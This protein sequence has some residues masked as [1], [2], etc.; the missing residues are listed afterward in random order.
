MK[1]PS[2]SFCSVCPQNLGNKDKEEIKLSGNQTKKT[3]NINRR[4]KKKSI[5]RFTHSSSS[6]MKRIAK[7]NQNKSKRHHRRPPA[8]IQKPIVRPVPPKK[9]THHKTQNHYY[10]IDHLVDVPRPNEGDTYLNILTGEFYLY[11]KDI[12]NLIPSNSPRCYLGKSLSISDQIPVPREGDV[13]FE[14]ET[15]HIQIYQLSEWIDFNPNIHQPR[16]S[17]ASQIPYSSET[18]LSRLQSN[19]SNQNKLD[20]NLTK[21]FELEFPS[22]QLQINYQD[23][24]SQYVSKISPTVV[25]KDQ[26]AVAKLEVIP[27]GLINLNL[28]FNDMNT[29]EIE[30]GFESWVKYTDL[31][32]KV[33]Q[34]VTCLTDLEIF[35]EAQE[36]ISDYQ[37]I[38]NQE[39][40]LVDIKQPT[41]TLTTMAKDDQVMIRSQSPISQIRWKTK[42]LAYLDTDPNPKNPK[43]YS[44]KFKDFNQPI[45]LPILSITLHI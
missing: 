33:W 13:Y 23:L 24:S 41:Q 11:T 3:K 4:R 6:V 31:Q 26:I 10:G 22:A 37:I 34:S 27:E 35:N 15:G 20:Q 5:T 25:A 29:T 14:A 43:F 39:N 30:F 19:Q 42:L 1:K 45:S 38:A 40:Q 36:I 7:I 32:Q 16:F 21:E 12:W 28:K 18:N 9:N 44:I 2:Q 17:L 8:R